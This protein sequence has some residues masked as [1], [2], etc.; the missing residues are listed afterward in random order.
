M[1]VDE[2]DEAEIAKFKEIAEQIYPQAAEVMGA[3]Y[4][5]EIRAAIEECV[6]E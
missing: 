2:L 4:W 6:A 1:E 5:E 3:D